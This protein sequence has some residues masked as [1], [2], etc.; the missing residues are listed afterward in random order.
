[1]YIL[2]NEYLHEAEMNILIIVMMLRT[3]PGSLVVEMVGVVV[4]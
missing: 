3:N 2:S 4:V 1:M